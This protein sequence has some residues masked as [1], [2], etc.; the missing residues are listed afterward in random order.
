MN[1]SLIDQSLLLATYYR[2][3]DLQQDNWTSCCDQVVQLSLFYSGDLTA[4]ECQ[5]RFSQGNVSGLYQDDGELVS[6][7]KMRYEQLIEVLRSHPHLIE[8]GGDFDSPA[9]PTFTACRL[10]EKG[11]ELIPEILNRF[12]Q[13]P[14]FPNWPD[15]R[16]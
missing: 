9:D 6:Q 10:T 4:E 11:L 3:N 8:G 16:I 5:S 13:K 14:E 12:P 2:G 15:K 7:V 1:L